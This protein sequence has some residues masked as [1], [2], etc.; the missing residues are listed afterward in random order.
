MPNFPEQFVER[1]KK[2]IDT[3]E[4][5][6]FFDAC[7]E[8]SK[9]AFRVNTLK[10]SVED[11]LERVKPYNWTLEPIPWEKTGFWID[12]EDTSVPLGSTI[13]HQS[14]QMYIQDASSM[15]PVALLGDMK[16]Q[17]VIDMAS[18]PGS[19][20][21]Q[22]AAK[23]D[24]LGTIVALDISPKRIGTL[25]QNLNRLGV[26]NAYTAK[27]NAVNLDDR[28]LNLFDTVLLDAP[29]SS[30]GLMWKKPEL[31]KKWDIK[32]V[33][34]FAKIQKQLLEVA[35]KICKPG[36]TIIYST[37]TMA[38]EENEGVVSHLLD[39]FEGE[40]SLKAPQNYDWYDAKNM[41]GLTA[42][43]DTKY[44]EEA[45]KCVR[46]WPHK[47]QGEAFFAAV[48]QKEHRVKRYH[49]KRAD[50]YRFNELENGKIFHAKEKKELCIFSKK[51]FGYELPITHRHDVRLKDHSIYLQNPLG[52]GVYQLMKWKRE[53][54]QIADRYKQ[55]YRLSH[56]AISLWGQNFSKNCLEVDEKQAKQ[57]MKGKDLFIEN[58]NDQDL[59]EGQIIVRYNGVALGS[60]LLRNGK[61]KNQL[62]R[63]L[64]VRK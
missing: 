63:E 61:V 19:K 62:P 57:Y 39:M 33:H 37:C 55:E 50:Q 21:S 29:C 40:C 18:A 34:F 59:D 7:L 8:T 24:N 2:I 1:Y 15:I 45:D 9:K 4:Y 52:Q 22:M 49:L 10:I 60:G 6:A 47:T 14:G 53:G 51:R 11:F 32:D 23:M 44:N 56:E 36:G 27:K 12:R 31:A 42:F 38:P 48:I 43:Q 5:E 28:W 13:E 30:E 41:K 3:S 25:A 16:K 46:I 26:I 58:N 20:T 54:L 64:V 17:A 35:F